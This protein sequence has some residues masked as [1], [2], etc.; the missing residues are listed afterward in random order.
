M[1]SAAKRQIAEADVPAL[2]G[3]PVRIETYKEDT[4]SAPHSG[5]GIVL[6]A[7]TSTGCILGGSALGAPRVSPEDTGV[8]AAEELLEAVES[9]GCV[10]KYIQ[11]QMIIFMALA[12]GSSTLVTGPITL[13]TETA[14]H[15]A[16]K[17][18][19]AKF[20][21]SACTENNRAWVITCEGIGL[22]NHNL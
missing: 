2:R 13:H 21:I 14:I 7:R 22:V 19:K 12:A 16:E 10:D 11:D 1:T 6:L 3:V 17:L 5:S 20:K 4:S 9:G 15:I 8:K 18:T